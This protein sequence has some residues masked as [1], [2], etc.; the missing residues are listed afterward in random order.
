[1]HI[2]VQVVFDL[3]WIFK[4]CDATADATA[5]QKRAIFKKCFHRWSGKTLGKHPPAR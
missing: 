4:F 5:T 2:N 3:S 1:M